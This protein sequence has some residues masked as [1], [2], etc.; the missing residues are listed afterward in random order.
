M[1]DAQPDPDDHGR[2]EGTDDA[3]VTGVGKLSEA[4]E[5]IER[6]RGRLFDFHQL[7]GRADFVLEE[8]ADLLDSAGQ[9]DAADRLRVEIIGRNVLDGRWTFQVI[10]EFESLYYGAVRAVEEEIRNE[11]MAGR[12]HVVEAELKE[13]RRTPRHPGHESRPPTTDGVD[14]RRDG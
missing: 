8:A 9:Q 10:E 14:A 5:W 1:A 6:A 12:R 2:P 7:I 4:V 11:L 13:R 3:T